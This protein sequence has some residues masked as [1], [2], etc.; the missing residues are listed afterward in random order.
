MPAEE[1][2]TNILL[3]P[4]KREELI[5]LM[6]RTIIFTNGQMESLPPPIHQILPSDI[7]IAADGG[8]RHC[9]TLGITPNIIIGDLDSLD[10]HDKAAYQAAGVEIIQHPSHKDETDLELAL[11]LALERKF[12]PVFILA[13]MGARWDMTIANVMLVAQEEYSGA[14]IRLLDGTQELGVLRGE[15]TLQMDGRLGDT[16]SLMPINGNA[17]GVTTFGLEYPLKNETLYFGSPRGVSNV[18]VDAHA[19]VFIKSGMLLV[20]LLKSGN[21]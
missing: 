8:T 13:A 14:N 12:S 9:K 4:V 21:E 10:K 16:L 20:C 6:T 11:Q 19:Q 7:I 3:P 18:I 1:S 15:A 2:Q 17:V 5:F